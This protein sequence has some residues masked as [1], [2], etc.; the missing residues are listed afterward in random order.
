MRLDAHA[1]DLAPPDRTSCD[2]RRRERERERERVDGEVETM[3]MMAIVAI[4]MVIILAMMGPMKLEPVAEAATRIENRGPNHET[5]Q[6][7][8]APRH[9]AD[10]TWASG[11]AEWSGRA[12]ERRSIG[13]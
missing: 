13:F 1:D 10:R 8:R 2:R 6:H 4:M 5:D 3:A 11:E 12:R 9:E 7:W